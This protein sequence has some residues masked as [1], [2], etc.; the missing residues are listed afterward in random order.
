MVAKQHKGGFTLI[1]LMIVVA[2]VA[3]LA[4]IAYPSYRDYVLR[5]QLVDA[6][7]ALAS[8]RA[9][10]ERHF[11][12]NRTY[13]TVGAFVSPCERADVAQRTVGNFVVSCQGTLDNSRYTLQAVG[14]GP[15]SGFTFTINQNSNKTTTAPSGW[16][17]C[18][19]GWAL[20][21]GQCAS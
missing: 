11:Q 3:V 21:R 13:A 5:G 4:A 14:S 19:P 16:G 18:D 1:E 9:E 10:M 6:T 15:V 17:N 12:D 20:K 2:V 7:N 8:F